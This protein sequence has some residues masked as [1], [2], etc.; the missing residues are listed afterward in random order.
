[1]KSLISTANLGALLIAIMLTF[2]VK[3]YSQFPTSIITAT[4][5]ANAKELS[6]YFN[7]KIELVLPQKSGV[8]SSSQAKLVLDDF[9]KNNPVSNFSI[10]HQ[11]KRETSAFAIGKYQSNNKVYRFYFLTKNKENKT[12]IHQLR[13]EKEDD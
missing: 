3:S 7:G 4:K 9:F 6:N 10:I 11:G 13:I 5:N 12:F 2:S 8:F 1:M